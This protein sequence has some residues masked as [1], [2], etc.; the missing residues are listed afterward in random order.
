VIIVWCTLKTV[1]LVVSYFLS[2]VWVDFLHTLVPS[3]SSA[4]WI[5]QISF[6]FCSVF[7]NHMIS[8]NV[9]KIVGGR[10]ILYHI[11]FILSVMVFMMIMSTY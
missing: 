11:S 6:V 1:L 3:V 10:W 4:V 7:Y 8:D 5:Y 2:V 9:G